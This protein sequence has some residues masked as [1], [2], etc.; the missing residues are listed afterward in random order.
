MTPTWSDRIAKW[1]WLI[2]T[3]FL[4][5]L[6]IRGV[7]LVLQNYQLDKPL[8]IIVLPASLSLIFIIVDLF[9]F[10]LSRVGVSS[11][12]NKNEKGYQPNLQIWGLGLVSGVGIAVIY[13]QGTVTL[14][15]L[16]QNPASVM[17]LLQNIALLVFLVLSLGIVTWAVVKICRYD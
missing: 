17:A 1:G 8:T 2:V 4:L 15:L 13:L 3:F 7:S 11:E 5:D 12:A 16:H 14:E 9:R 10:G 6:V